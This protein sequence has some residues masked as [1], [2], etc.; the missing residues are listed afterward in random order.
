MGLQKCSSQIL[1]VLPPF[2]PVICLHA[3]LGFV[4][5]FHS[6]GSVHT[7]QTSRSWQ[8]LGSRTWK[9]IMAKNPFLSG[10]RG[11]LF[12]CPR[13]LCSIVALE[14]SSLCAQRWALQ[15]S[16]CPVWLR[17]GEGT[18]QGWFSSGCW[19]HCCGAEKGWWSPLICVSCIF[20]A[21]GLPLAF[22]G[23]D[24]TPQTEFGILFDINYLVKLC[25]RASWAAV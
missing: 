5:G 24:K 3:L 17:V 18:A 8:P 22:S 9:A 7:E 21:G 2:S 6:T 25:P 4:R 12:I 20:G 13:G 16:E 14:G 19:R 1:S 11:V 23:V 10:T 15:V